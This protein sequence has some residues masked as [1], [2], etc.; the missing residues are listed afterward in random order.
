MFWFLLRYQYLV[1]PTDKNFAYFAHRFFLTQAKFAHWSK[2]P[3]YATAGM[4][5][6]L[7]IAGSVVSST[8]RAAQ[9]FMRPTSAMFATAVCNHVGAT[10]IIAPYWPHAILIWL[11]GIMPTSWIDYISKKTV[12]AISHKKNN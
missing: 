6:E 10:N 5:V 1:E 3:G 12:K 8:N 2:N 9:S 4:R 7:H 11:F